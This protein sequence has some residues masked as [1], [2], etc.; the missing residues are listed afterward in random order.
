M[1]EDSFKE[2]FAKR[3]NYRR[4]WSAMINILLHVVWH[5]RAITREKEAGRCWWRGGRLDQLKR[6]RP[7]L[8]VN[9]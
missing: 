8:S 2:Q 9:K 6:I 7:W 3:K 5:G 4:H 1:S